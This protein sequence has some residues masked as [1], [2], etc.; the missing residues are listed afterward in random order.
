MLNENI[1]QANISATRAENLVR[2]KEKQFEQEQES[3]TRRNE[4]NAKLAE[5]Q[6]QEDKVSMTH[7]LTLLCFDCFI[8]KNSY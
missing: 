2:E 5:C 6:E 3:M 7:L 4:L 8:D 1:N